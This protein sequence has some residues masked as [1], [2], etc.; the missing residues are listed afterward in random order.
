MSCA[1]GTANSVAR[2]RRMEVNGE[3][4]PVGR[5]KII[6][7]VIGPEAKCKSGDEKIAFHHE[8]VP[9]SVRELGIDQEI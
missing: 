7:L 9:P 5:E 3:P 6:R 2:S 1:L 4:L 8:K